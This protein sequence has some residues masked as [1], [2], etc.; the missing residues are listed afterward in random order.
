MQKKNVPQ[1][2]LFAIIF[3]IFELPQPWYFHWIPPYETQLVHWGCQVISMNNP[4]LA[5]W[6]IL[7]NFSHPELWLPKHT[8]ALQALFCNLFQS[9]P[10]L[11]LGGAPTLSV[12]FP[13]IASAVAWVRLGKLRNCIPATFKIRKMRLPHSLKSCRANFQ[14]CKSEIQICRWYCGNQSRIF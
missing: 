5:L 11:S 7:Q 1:D 12:V 14:N 2:F 6:V 3:N 8:F 9:F 4:H 13:S 10:L